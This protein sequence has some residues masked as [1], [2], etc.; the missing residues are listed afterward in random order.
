MS[1]QAEIPDEELE[2]RLAAIEY[3]QGSIAHLAPGRNL[4]DELIADRRQPLG[5]RGQRDEE[6]QT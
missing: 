3:A 2:K 1:G 4:A 5:R 6:P